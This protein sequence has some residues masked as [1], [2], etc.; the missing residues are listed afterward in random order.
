MKKLIAALL[1]TTLLFGCASA[2]AEPT[3]TTL[4]TTEAS[5]NVTPDTENAEQRPESN[6]A[7]GYG[8]NALSDRIY[9]VLSS[10]APADENMS[11]IIAVDAKGENVYD[12]GQLQIAFW[13]E[14]QN[15]V[16]SYGMYLS[17]FGLDTTKP[18][19]EQEYEPGKTWEQYF[20]ENAIRGLERNCRLIK[21]QVFLWNGASDWL[22]LWDI[23]GTIP[24]WNGYKKG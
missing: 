20:L 6:I 21:G 22:D 8:N 19:S 16:G 5:E 3:E 23:D 18:L 11:K 24:G 17:Y 15:F 1:L 2:P 13:T 14:Y 7:A 9:Y 4:P 10:A 12:N